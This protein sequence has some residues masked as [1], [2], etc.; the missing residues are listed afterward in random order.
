MDANVATWSPD[1]SYVLAALLVCFYAWARFN[2]P[3]AVR[4]QTSRLQYFASGSA[5]VLSCLGLLMAM[6]WLLRQRPQIL[7]VLHSG[8]TDALPENLHGLDAALVSALILTT[9][10]PSFPMVRDVDR[11]MLAFFHKMGA[12]PFGAMLWA[13]RMEAAAFAISEGM[14]AAA[15]QFILNS[16]S[17]PNTLMDE[18]QP[19][20]GGDQ[21]RF[22]F[23]RNLVLYVDMNQMRGRARFA[24]EFPEDVEQFERRMAEFFANA[25]GFFALSR[26]LSQQQL[27]AV[28]QTADNFK[29]LSNA[30]FDYIQEM[31]ARMLLFTCSGEA[32][33]AQKLNAFGFAVEVPP[34]V[35]MPLNLLVFDAIG[36]VALFAASTLFVP[37][38]MPVMTAVSVGFL[39]A[40]NHVIAGAFALLPKQVW[41]FA[42][43]RCA[44]ERPALAYLISALSTLTITLP[45]CYG[46]YLLRLNVLAP[47][48][49]ILPFAAQCKWLML[50]TVLAFALAFLC[51]DY[52]RTGQEPPALRWLEG[53]GLGILLALTGLLTMRWLLPDQLALH[54]GGPVPSLWVPVAMSASIGVL[55]GATIPTWY[56]ATVRGA[57]DVSSWPASTQ[58]QPA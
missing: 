48:M 3:H 18:L 29:R 10:L 36:V 2:T 33:V 28:A 11:R 40:V 19:D 54:H 31:L 50:P 22:H 41:S 16:S 9:L 8:A 53:A 44:H 13:Q 12:I 30:A 49:P 38:N 57:G 5:Y 34:P 17:L 39:V 45:I 26:E 25:I 58:A 55:F 1:A 52:A 14:L 43:I 32:D 6:T 20:A 4:S 37:D 21:A 7:D 23:T 27:A 42:D 24:N 56:R 46:F 15:R 35:R 51:D 47:G